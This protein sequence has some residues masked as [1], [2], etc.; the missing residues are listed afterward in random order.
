MKTFYALVLCA[1]FGLAA[2]HSNPPAA[3]SPTEALRLYFAASQKQDIAAMKALLSR[4]SLELIEKSARL[5]NTTGDELLR[6][7]SSVKIQK[8][9]ATRNER[10]EGDA[11]TVEIK[12]ETSGDFD[13]TMPFVREDGKWKLARDKFVEES[14]RKANE[15]INRKLA[16]SANSVVNSAPRANNSA[17]E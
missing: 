6:R 11:A 8:A 10:I 5:Q 9:P 12:N 4:G 17:N 15:E 14:L 7:E 3:N 16:N 2:C 13:M 1:A